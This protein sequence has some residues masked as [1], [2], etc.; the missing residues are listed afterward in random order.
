MKTDNH[1]RTR[2]EEKYHQEKCAEKKRCKENEKIIQIY[3]YSFIFNKW[4]L[5]FGEQVI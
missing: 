3:I 1:I 5:Q 2:S 4:D